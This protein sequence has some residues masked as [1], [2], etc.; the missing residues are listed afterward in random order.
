MKASFNKTLFLLKC[1]L[2]KT[3]TVSDL[4]PARRSEQYIEVNF[5]INVKGIVN[6]KT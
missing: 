3:N 2:E 5:S 1:F 4:K 6:V